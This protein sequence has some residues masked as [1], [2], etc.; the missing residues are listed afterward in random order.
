MLRKRVWMKLGA[1]VAVVAAVI[2]AQSFNIPQFLSQFLL[3][4][5][6]R[7]NLSSW[8]LVQ[9]VRLSLP[10][11]SLCLL[12]FAA[13]AAVFGFTLTLSKTSCFSKPATQGAS[14]AR[15]RGH[16]IPEQLCAYVNKSTESW[17]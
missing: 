17:R 10:P 4:S 16:K 3:D 5:T 11:E 8:Q 15:R 2:L 14:K 9:A 7:T 13:V 6:S 12:V 1:V